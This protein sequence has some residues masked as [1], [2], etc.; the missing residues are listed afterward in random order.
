MK[1][2]HYLHGMKIAH[3]NLKPSNILVSNQHYC[4]KDEVSF[5][6]EYEHCPIVCKVAYFGL[7]RSLDTQNQSILQSCTNDI[8]PVVGRFSWPQR[9]IWDFD[10][11]NPAG[12]AEDGYLVTWFVDLF[13]S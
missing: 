8:F 7:S 2:L 4:N 13:I 11:S 10:L 1:G 5:T 3:I 9:Y 12:F 6:R